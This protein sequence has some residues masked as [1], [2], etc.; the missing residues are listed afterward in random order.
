MVHLAADQRSLHSLATV[1]SN[2]GL[3][4]FAITVESLYWNGPEEYLERVKD[5]HHI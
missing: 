3:E 2:V 4:C 5:I 1:T